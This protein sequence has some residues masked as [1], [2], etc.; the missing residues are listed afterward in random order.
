MKKFAI[1]IAFFLV[2]LLCLGAP[3]GDSVYENPFY[4]LTLFS[5]SLFVTLGIILP[6]KDDLNNDK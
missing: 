5:M 1:Y 4:L 2:V 6:S 3:F